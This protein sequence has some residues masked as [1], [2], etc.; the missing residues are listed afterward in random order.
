M[1]CC[2]ITERLIP[3]PLSLSLG[4]EDADEQMGNE[5]AI[6]LKDII[7][8]TNICFVSLMLKT[9]LCCFLYIKNKS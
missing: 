2:M 1:L 3:F 8:E 6:S 7:P 9:D 4:A 5:D